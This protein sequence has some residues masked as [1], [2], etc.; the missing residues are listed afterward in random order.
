MMMEIKII[1]LMIIITII[2]I[3]IILIIE[4]LKRYE[5]CPVGRAFTVVIL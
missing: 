4:T 5:L 2:M 3:M 1:I